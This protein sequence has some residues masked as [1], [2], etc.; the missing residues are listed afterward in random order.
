MKWERFF[1]LTDREV[2]PESGHR[3]VGRRRKGRPVVTGQAGQ[4][5]VHGGPPSSPKFMGCPVAVPMQS[6]TS[7]LVSIQLTLC[8]GKTVERDQ[9]PLSTS[10][11]NI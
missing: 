2:G 8:G 10:Q 3:D 4:W 6:D 7:F 5:E 9:Y 11:G 1:T